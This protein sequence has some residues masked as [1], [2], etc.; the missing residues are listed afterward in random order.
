MSSSVAVALDTNVRLIEFLVYDLHLL[1]P[2]PQE[3]KY[4]FLD[5]FRGWMAQSLLFCSMGYS[6]GT[7]FVCMH[8]SF[9]CTCMLHSMCTRDFPFISVPTYEFCSLS[10]SL[11]RSATLISTS[12]YCS[13]VFHTLIQY[14]D[15]PLEVAAQE[16]HTTTVQRMLEAGI[17]VN[18]Q[19]KVMT[20]YLT[21]NVITHWDTTQ[22]TQL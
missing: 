15:V 14:G 7:W 22:S 2:Q 1:W 20:A 11:I 17:S 21:S 6:L 18:H 16:G 3:R 12:N 9:L 13:F 5:G 10:L 4:A 8:M 19:T